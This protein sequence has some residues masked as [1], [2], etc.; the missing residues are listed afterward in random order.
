MNYF[1]RL[2]FFARQR[3][4]TLTELIV[5][6]TIATVILTTLVIQQSKWNDHLAVNVQAYELAMMIRQAQ[7]YSLGVR[8]YPGGAGDNF[9][10]GYGIHF[11]SGPGNGLMQY[12][13]FADKNRNGKYDSVDNEEIE[14]KTFT[15]GVTIQRFCGV[16]SVGNENERCHEGEGNV[17]YINITFLRPEPKSNVVFLNASG[18]NSAIMIEPAVVVYLKSANNKIASVRVEA[19]GQV[20]ITQ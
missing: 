18:E 5:V 6:V 4:F 7:V 1:F 14:I 20:S 12:I 8:E 15:R 10:I 19:N 11:G 16:K 13:F 17:R 2:K 9:N 3:G